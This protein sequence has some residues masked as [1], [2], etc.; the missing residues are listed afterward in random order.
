[1]CS[2]VCAEAHGGWN[3]AL[4][5]PGPEVIGGYELSCAYWELNPGPLPKQ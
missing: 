3:E 1:M 5:P 4:E 2:H